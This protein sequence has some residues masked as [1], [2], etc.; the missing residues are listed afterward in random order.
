VVATLRLT[1]DLT[2][3]RKL[4]TP[5]TADTYDLLRLLEEHGAG[6]CGIDLTAETPAHYSTWQVD[7]GVE[8]NVNQVRGVADM[9]TS[10]H[11]GWVLRM[12]VSRT[13]YPTGHD[14]LDIVRELKTEIRPDELDQR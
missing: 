8:L 14:L 2:W 13:L 7:A 12:E 3:K 10:L 11:P 1:G 4:T 6:L 5:A 9:L